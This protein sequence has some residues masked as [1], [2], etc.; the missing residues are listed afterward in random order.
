MEKLRRFVPSKF[1][2]TLGVLA[3][4]ATLAAPT[5]AFARD[6]SIVSLRSELQAQGRNEALAQRGTGFKILLRGQTR[7]LTAAHVAVPS[8]RIEAHCG[9]RKFGLKVERYSPTLDLALLAPTE[10]E[11]PQVARSVPLLRHPEG[12]TSIAATE[13]IAREGM[14]RGLFVGFAPNR[15]LDDQPIGILI[16]MGFSRSSWESLDLVSYISALRPGFSGSPYLVHDETKQEFRLGGILLQTKNF[17]GA[18]RGLSTRRIS[19]FLALTDGRSLSLP[20]Q[21]EWQHRRLPRGLER[22]RS[23]VLPDGRR[24]RET[25]ANRRSVDVSNWQPIGG[26]DW[27]DGGGA[28]WAD[29]GRPIGAGDGSSRRIFSNFVVGQNY[30]ASF[31]RA[32]DR[33]GLS[34]ETGTVI[35]IN[36]SYAEVSRDD[37]ALRA[38]R[39]SDGRILWEAKLRTRSDRVQGLDD[40]LGLFD[41]STP[42]AAE[43]ARFVARARFVGEEELKRPLPLPV[44]AW[45][46]TGLR[47]GGSTMNVSIDNDWK[48][49]FASLWRPPLSLIG[50][51]AKEGPIL[52]CANG[53]RELSIE[54]PFV[55]AKLTSQGV[56]GSATG[57]RGRVAF[58]NAAVDA[59]GFR[60]SLKADG[61]EIDY[62]IDFDSDAEFFM[63]MSQVL[64]QIPA[65]SKSPW[66]TMYSYSIGND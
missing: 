29:G 24:I 61:M 19:E 23:L 57:P 33:L 58:R 31:G 65:G 3:L 17:G 37:C 30:T 50:A 43:L 66:L 4:L 28:D 27:A 54:S 13:R 36:H 7:Y 11:S 59:W 2:S 38:L 39:W 18:V 47:A 35:G 51:M 46:G 64:P 44:C 25:C 6:C 12:E 16:D 48:R 42:F 5:V 8:D 49:R 55:N 26:A 9:G 45:I 32:F 20:F 41:R 22:T 53:G 62:Q 15:T 14:G 56:T 52:R 1:W 60:A 10:R 63:N 40:L 34:P 21:I